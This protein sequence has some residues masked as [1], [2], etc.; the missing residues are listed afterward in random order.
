MQADLYKNY[1]NVFASIGTIKAY[2]QSVI[3]ADSALTATQAG[4]QVG[5]RTIVD[6]LNSTT[7]LYFAKQKLSDARYNYILNTLQLK[8]TAGT[9][10]EQDLLDI[11]NG[12]M[13]KKVIY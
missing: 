8:Q 2:Q 9:L 11:N 6:V 5:T 10:S 13:T 4:Y 12:L 3:S 1:N 7:K